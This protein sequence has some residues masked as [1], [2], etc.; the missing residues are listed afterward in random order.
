[1]SYNL[2]GNKEQSSGKSIRYQSSMQPKKLARGLGITLW[3]GD[4]NIRAPCYRALFFGL[5]EINLGFIYFTTQATPSSNSYL[6]HST[7]VEITN[8][9]II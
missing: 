6:P 1:M 2:G 9:L 3:L 4:H 7:S 8:R 5:W